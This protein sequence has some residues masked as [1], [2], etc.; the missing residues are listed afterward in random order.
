MKFLC[1]GYGEGNT[2]ET[3]SQS[4][5]NAVI[6]ECFAYDEQLYRA[7][8][9]AD[10]G[11]CLQAAGSAKTLRWK[12]GKVIVTDG[13][14]A[15]TKE[16]LGGVGILE[17][18]DID[19]A[20]ELVSKHP[21]L[22]LGGPFEIRPIDEETLARNLALDAEYRPAS[23]AAQDSAAETARFAC[24]GYI[25]ESAWEGRLKSE[26]D[27]MLQECVA[28]DV[29]RRKDGHWLSG[30][31]LQSPETAKTVRAI[32]GNV[33]VTDGP[34]AETKE[35]LGGVVVLGLRD[36]S[37]AVELISTHPGLGFGVSIEI[38]PVNEEMNA[39]WEARQEKLKAH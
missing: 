6:E 15:E 33:V 1:L 28:Y 37:H 7:G 35:W 31:A 10:G 23:A 16:Q 3:M 20:V 14:F 21:G 39:R 8:Y 29:A 27:A 2:W 24:L 25:S 4:E 5:K 22:R 30:I 34:Y 38:R 32:D 26:F 9:W 36:M 13:P 18:K 11:E 19:H 17:A 12:S